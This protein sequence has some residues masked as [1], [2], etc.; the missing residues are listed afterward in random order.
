[1]NINGTNIAAGI[2][3][4]TTEDTFATHDSLYG[5]GGW[6]EVDTIE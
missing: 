1:M 4:Y 3:P 5:K 6:K 2:V